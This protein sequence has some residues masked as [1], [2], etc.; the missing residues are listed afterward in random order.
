MLTVEPSEVRAGDLAHV[1]AAGRTA[2]DATEFL[3]SLDV[4]AC[5]RVCVCVCVCV[6]LC[7]CV[8]AWRQQLRATHIRVGL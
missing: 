6:C 7:V 8:C 4:G 5:A 2:H 3:R 1:A